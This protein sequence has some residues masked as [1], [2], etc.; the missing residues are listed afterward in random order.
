MNNIPDETGII[1]SVPLLIEYEN[2]LYP[3]LALEMYRIAVNAN[4]VIINYSEAGI[5]SINLAKQNI[6][7]DR[8]GRISRENAKEIAKRIK[9]LN[10]IVAKVNTRSIHSV[11]KYLT[12]IYDREGVGRYGS[13]LVIDISSATKE[14]MI[15]GC[16]FAAL[17]RSVA[18]LYSRSEGGDEISFLVNRFS[19]SIVLSRDIV[20]LLKE[21]SVVKSSDRPSMILFTIPSFKLGDLTDLERKILKKVDEVGGAVR[22]IRDVIELVGFSSEDSSIRSAFSR[23]IDSLERK[24]LVRKI[25]MGKTRAVMLTDLGKFIARLLS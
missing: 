21:R 25:F 19:N 22:A 9:L 2:E 7:S 10:P 3:S 13:E 14:S 18:V 8:F 20:T 4:K 24:G 16:I 17:R 1:R 12:F 23:C 5:E 6:R 11:L 15:A